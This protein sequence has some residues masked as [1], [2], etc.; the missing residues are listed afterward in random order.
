[1]P[2]SIAGQPVPELAVATGSMLRKRNDSHSEG[3]RRAA[4]ASLFLLELVRWPPLVQISNTPG[5]GSRSPHRGRRGRSNPG[6]TRGR[7]LRQYARQVTLGPAALLPPDSFRP[8]GPFVARRPSYHG[9][10]LLHRCHTMV[11]CHRMHI[12]PIHEALWPKRNVVL[13]RRITDSLWGS[14]PCRLPRHILVKSIPS[15]AVP[16]SM[17]R[18][19]IARSG[20]LL[21]SSPVWNLEKPTP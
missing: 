18:G 5:V 19:R 14:Q 16:P 1:M 9:G 2:Q 21:S 6:R 10:K 15:N 17:A 8:P 4:Q 3:A 12:T 11:R 7:R 13:Q 20:D